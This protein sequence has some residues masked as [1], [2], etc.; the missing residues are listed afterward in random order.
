MKI[1]EWESETTT[2]EVELTGSELKAAVLAHVM[3][4]AGNKGVVIRTG[5]NTGM[6]GKVCAG[7]AQ[8][9]LDKIT[10]VEV[11]LITVKEGQKSD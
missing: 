1:T 5:A 4:K 10:K 6:Y 11:K 9:N 8:L 2:V 7:T 3:N